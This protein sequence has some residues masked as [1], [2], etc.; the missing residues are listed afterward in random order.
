MNPTCKEENRD[1]EDDCAR[2][3]TTQT[4]EEEICPMRRPAGKKRRARETR[5]LRPARN[6]LVLGGDPPGRGERSRQDDSDLRGR[7]VS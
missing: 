7:D 5:R 1:E 6:R 3:E 4:C 2:D